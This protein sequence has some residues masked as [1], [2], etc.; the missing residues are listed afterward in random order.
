MGILVK[1]LLEDYLISA[2]ILNI[3]EFSL[4]EQLLF[5]LRKYPEFA[6]ESI[7]QGVLKY[8]EGELTI[9]STYSKQPR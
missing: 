7:R 5:Q 2:K 6:L 9:L 1:E 3:Y 4:N 8:I